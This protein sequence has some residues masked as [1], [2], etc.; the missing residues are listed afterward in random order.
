MTALF[1]SS[2][3]YQ[4]YRVSN[5]AFGAIKDVK[6]LGLEKTFT[7]RFEIPSRR[8]VTYQA[9]GDAIRQLPQFALQALAFVIVMLIVWYQ[10]AVRDDISQALP[11]IALYALAGSRLMPALQ[12]IYHSVSSL[13][14]AKPALDA[15]HKDLNEPAPKHIK[16]RNQDSMQTLYLRDRLDISAVT[17][18]YPGS[19]T[20]ALR[21]VSLS[22]P[23]GAAVGL[24]GQTGAGKTT[25]VDVMLCLLK[26]EAGKLTASR[27]PTPRAAARSSGHGYLA[28]HSRP[29]SSASSFM[30]WRRS[31]SRCINRHQPAPR[32]GILMANWCRDNRSAGT[33]FVSSLT[34]TLAF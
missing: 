31:T 13:R 16:A 25:L 11:I 14:Y 23:A 18:R 19:P 20:P 2:V 10:L 30:W 15:L 9:A 22:I 33:F 26:P 34:K 6:L 32:V 3:E 17:Y 21:G 24:V 12:G 4:R 1:S 5:E 27:S 29:M 8:F 28:D 7:S